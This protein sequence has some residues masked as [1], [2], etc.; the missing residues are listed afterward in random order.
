[1]INYTDRLVID[2]SY[3]Y[4]GSSN[5]NIIIEMNNDD[6]IIRCYSSYGELMCECTSLK[7]LG[8]FLNKLTNDEFA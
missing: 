3:Y 5:H 6:E 2:D 7:Q 8:K 1:M 4:K